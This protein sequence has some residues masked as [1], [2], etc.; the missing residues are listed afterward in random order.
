MFTCALIVEIHIDKNG[1]QS[2]PNICKQFSK[3]VCYFKLYACEQK[4]VVGI[5]SNI[6][7]VA[8]WCLWY[9]EFMDMSVL[10]NMTPKIFSSSD[11]I[12]TSAVSSD[13]NDKTLFS[14]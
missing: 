14:P 2:K 3:G 4:T 5:Y 13:I 12:R 10:S 7:G 6:W 8:R 11:V 1:W 9:L